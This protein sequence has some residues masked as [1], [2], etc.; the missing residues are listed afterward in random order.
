MFTN[1][2]KRIL[3]VFFVFLLF[4]L[5]SYLIDP[6]SED[7][8]DYFDRSPLELLTEWTISFIFCLLISESSIFIHSRLNAYIPW[9][10]NTPKRLAL[11]IG[12]NFTMVTLWI[13]LDIVS[14]SLIFDGSYYPQTELSTEEIKGLIQWIVASMIISFVIIAINTGSYLINS[15]V[16]TEMEMTETKLRTAELKRA[17][18]E[19]ELN[20]LK[21][22][23]DPHFIFNNLSVLSELILKDQKLGYEYSENFSKVYRF[24][25]VNSKK[26]MISL[27]E[28]LKFLHSYIFL[29]EHRIGEGVRFEIDVDKASRKMSIPPLTLQLLVENALKH[30]KTSKDTPLRIKICN[31]NKGELIVENTLS[32]I[33]HPDRYPTG[34]GLNNIISRF[35]LLSEREPEILKTDDVFRVIIYL[36]TYDQ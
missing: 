12:L 6:Y 35:K 21:L 5:V 25:L 1:K 18:V 11:E 20:A 34:I 24:L 29:T 9:T 23:L 7:W 22:Q 4:Y 15:W 8:K 2:S 27:E 28:E 14:V 33:D 30:N 19:A 36:I 3:F 10:K 17:S 31:G 32:L 16:Q 13:L 26:N